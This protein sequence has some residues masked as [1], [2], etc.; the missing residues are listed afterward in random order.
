[1]PKTIPHPVNITFLRSLTRHID[2]DTGHVPVLHD[3][4]F[5]HIAMNEYLSDLIKT[6]TFLPCVLK[7]I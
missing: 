7:V 6:T 4:Y 5:Q 1:M 2:L 3:I